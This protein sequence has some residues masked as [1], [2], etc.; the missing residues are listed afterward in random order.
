MKDN[1]SYYIKRCN[2]CY[3]ILLIMLINKKNRKI[4]ND[5]G[6]VILDSYFNN[7]RSIIWPRFDM[8][9]DF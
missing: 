8:I 7:I 1:F 5:K 2:D 4:A 9:F 6:I 3:A